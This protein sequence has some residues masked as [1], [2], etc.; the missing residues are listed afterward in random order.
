MA[1]KRFSLS[2]KS[3]PAVRGGMVH[4]GAQGTADDFKRWL[5]EDAYKKANKAKHLSEVEASDEKPKPKTRGPNKP[6]AGE[7][8]KETPDEGSDN[9]GGGSETGGGATGGAQ[10]A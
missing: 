7:P 2:G 9:G 5:G 6:K 3:Y 1:E 10:R 4:K 8:S